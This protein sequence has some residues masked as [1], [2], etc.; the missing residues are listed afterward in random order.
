MIEKKD[1]IENSRFHTKVVVMGGGLGKRLES[2]TGGVIPKD[3]VEIDPDRHIRGI[4]NTQAALEDSSLTDIIYSGSRHLP[5]Y[6]KELSKKNITY[7]FQDET[8]GHGKELMTIINEH[9]MNSQYLVLPTDIYFKSSDLEILLQQHKPGTVSWGVTLNSYPEMEAY[10]NLVVR[11]D[12]FAI[13]CKTH[14]RFYPLVKNDPRTE[15]VYNTVMIIFDPV[16]F[17][18]AYD[19]WT[20]LERPSGSVDLYRDIGIILAEENR[21]G[22]QRGR[23]SFLNAIQFLHPVM[24]YGTIPSLMALRASFQKNENTL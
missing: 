23:E 2:I 7:H 9:G 3:F 1:G 11:K 13:I 22:I 17:K 15:L 18:H 19:L 14:S 20:R 24:D 10:K 12:S 8:F 16:V 21:R 4:D 5:L 6:Q